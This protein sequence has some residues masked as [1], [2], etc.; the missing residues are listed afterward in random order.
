MAG[1][2]SVSDQGCQIIYYNI[3]SLITSVPLGIQGA[4]CTLIGQY[5]GEGDIEK[6]RICYG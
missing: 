4:V 1:T 6:A 3:Y 5:I 2:I